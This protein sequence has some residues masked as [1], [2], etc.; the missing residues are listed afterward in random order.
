MK[1]QFDSFSLSRIIDQALVYQCAC[2]AQVCRSILELRE[3]YDYQRD[4]ANDSV[5]DR[6]VH[7]TIAEATSLAH[8]TMEQ[9]LD[10]ILVIEGWDKTTLTMPESLR[11]K[12]AKAL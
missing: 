12:T 7:D 9:C 3:L 4:C 5:N 2:P 8:E 1:Y 11:K 6:S 10:Q